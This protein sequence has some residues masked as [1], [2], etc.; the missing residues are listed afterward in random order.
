MTTFL[1]VRRMSHAQSSHRSAKQMEF[2]TFREGLATKEARSYGD[3][4]FECY[5]FDVG[6]YKVAF[7]CFNVSWLS[8]KREIVGKIQFPFTRYE[9]KFLEP[10]SLRIAVFHHPFN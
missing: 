4:L 5:E 1:V 8:R 3:R 6:G 7:D 2:M 9:Q 10:M